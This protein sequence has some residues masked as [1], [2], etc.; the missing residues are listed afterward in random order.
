MAKTKIPCRTFTLTETI[1]TAYPFSNPP[2]SEPIAKPKPMMIRGLTRG[3]VINRQC[4]GPMGLSQK[5][6]VL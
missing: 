1:P 3:P 4:P 2:N 6:E 5:G